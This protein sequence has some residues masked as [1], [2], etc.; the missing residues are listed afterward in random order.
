VRPSFS[1]LQWYLLLPTQGTSSFNYFI[2]YMQDSKS[3]DRPRVLHTLTD[4]ERM[5]TNVFAGNEPWTANYNAMA[6]DPRS[7][8]TYVMAGPFTY[9]T[10]D[11]TGDQTHLSAIIEDGRAAIQL[12]LRWY[13]T[14]ET[15]FAFASAN[16]L[17]PW[18]S[19][20]TLINGN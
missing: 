11:H 19:T 10:R 2:F 1:I 16:I 18:A 3:N 7:A 9:F 5:R 4:L 14:N 20:L 13:I 6:A 8:A 17:N 12:A 15:S